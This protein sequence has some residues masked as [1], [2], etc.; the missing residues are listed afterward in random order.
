MLGAYQL[1]SQRDALLVVPTSADAAHYDRELAEQGLLLGRALTFPRLIEEI[2]RRARFDGVRLTPLQQDRLLRQVIASTELPSLERSA[3]SPGFATAAARLTAELGQ[4]RA[5]APRFAAA[6][7][8]W[9]ADSPDQAQFAR[10]LGAIHLRYAAELER[11]GVLDA[12]GFAWAALDALRRAPDRWQSTPVY[13]YGFDDLTPIELD[14]IA[15]LSGPA[16]A[17]V[18]VSLTYE[19][20]RPALAARARVVEELRAQATTVTQLPPLDEYYA[21]EARSALHHLERHLFEPGAPALDPGA[22]VVLLEAGGERAEAEMIADEVSS[23]LQSGVAPDELVVVTRSL[24]RSGLLLDRAL[25]RRGIATTSARRA[26]L[27]H[28]ALGRGLVAL[29][30]CALA[31]SSAGAGDVIA[32]LRTPGVVE[33]RGALDA[34][35][36]RIMRAGIT[37]LEAARALPGAAALSIAEIDRLRHAAEPL[38]GLL[39]AVRRLL[40]APQRTQS[41]SLS[42]GQPLSAGERLDATAAVTVIE[43]LEQVAAIEH[44]PAELI[45]LLEQLELVVGGVATPET[46]LIAEPLAIRARRFRQVI[47][48]GLCEGE[49]PSAQALTADPFLGDDGRHQLALASGLALPAADDPLARERYLLYACVSRATERVTVSYR[50]SDEDGNLVTPSPFIDDL[51][52]LFGPDWRPRRRRRLLGDLDPRLRDLPGAGPRESSA[53][54]T[55]VPVGTRVPVETRTP[56]GTRVLGTTAREHVRHTRVVSGNALE[57][58][59]ACPVRW[60]IESQ[61]HP[62]DLKP[63]PEPLAKGSFMHRVLERVV[64]D[65]AAP[66]TPATLP[67]AEDLLAGA[68]ADPEIDFAP[69]RRAEV[70]AALLRGIEADLRRYLRNEAITGNGWTPLH[71]ELQFGIGEDNQYPGLALGDGEDAVLLRGVIDRIDIEPGTGRAIVRDYKS[72]AKQQDWASNRWL[73]GMKVQVALYMLVVRRLLELDVVGGFYHPLTGGD[74]RPRGAY[75]AGVDAGSA[76]Y[77]GDGLDAEALEEL[78][79]EIEQEAVELARRLRRGELTPCPETCSGSF[80]GGC[81]HP[82]I[83]WAES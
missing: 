43:A 30:R 23:A 11:R 9:A 37:Q 21:P 80:G 34:Y 8:A 35:E 36:A 51:E 58:F 55:G 48:A 31:P 18:T 7:S 22:A 26:P 77:P 19:P 5:S 69:G 13:L 74:L 71:A 70:R 29:A 25:A 73:S 40:A 24:A 16:G 78:L 20:D 47:V 2:A 72:G 42:A 66:L 53:P 61:L 50:S 57:S 12:E 15:T 68:I 17:Q 45:E 1:A 64:R 76:T 79:E 83:C 3:A 81:R 27:T 14:A 63:E 59:A 32:Y 56:A 6:L 49:F 82:G 10:D 39:E 44:H 41:E 28:T 75:L 33:D 46:V 4:A 65:L 60:L 62:E 52:Q 54:A 38:A 67:R